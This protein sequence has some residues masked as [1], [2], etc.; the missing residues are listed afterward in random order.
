MNAFLTDTLPALLL[1]LLLKSALLL[2]AACA[3]CGLLRRASAA[4]RHLVWSAALGGVL[5]LPLMTLSLPRW[6]LAWTT[7]P[8]APLLQRLSKNKPGKC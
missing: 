1:G 4:T 5:L 2:I 8:P 6:D 3:A 7:S